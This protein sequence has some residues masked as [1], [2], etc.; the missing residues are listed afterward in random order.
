M[1][2]GISVKLPLSISEDDGAYSLNKTLAESTQQNLKMLVLTAPGE[3]V[4]DPL[5]GV[6]LRNFLFEMNEESTYALIGEKIREQVSK[7][8]PF[9]D[10]S[11]IDI[12]D[13]QLAE[14]N[15]IG[16]SI[17]IKIEYRILPL[18]VNDILLIVQQI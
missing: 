2:S 18:D 6:G 9:L 11:S 15:G 1:A 5:F 12:S 14:G 3:R 13:P 7:Y 17:S 10:L 16:N 8:L 4:M